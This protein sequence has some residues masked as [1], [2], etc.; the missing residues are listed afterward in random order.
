MRVVRTVVRFAS[1]SIM[2]WRYFRAASMSS[3]KCLRMR[4]QSFNKG[5]T[6]WLRPDV[7]GFRCTALFNRIAIPVLR[8]GAASARMTLGELLALVTSFFG[9]LLLWWALRVE[10]LLLSVGPLFVDSFISDDMLDLLSSFP[11][12]NFIMGF[13]SFVLSC[14][15]ELL[16]FSHD[17]SS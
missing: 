11:L 14:V 15:G 7:L 13:D 3:C 6:S 5:T 4:S 16:R 9:L 10:A 2:V 8:C 17:R 12:N 1:K